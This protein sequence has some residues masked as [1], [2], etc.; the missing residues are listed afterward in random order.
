MSE[1]SRPPRDWKQLRTKII[2]LG[3]ESIRKSYYPELQQRLREIQASEAK[4]RAIFDSVTDA[5]LVQ[6]IATGNI[7]DVNRPMCTPF[8][9]SCDEALQLTIDQLSPNKAPY[10]SEAF[11]DRISKATQGE[12][13]TF[14]WLIQTKANTQVWVEISL[15]RAL[16]GS[17]ERLLIMIR[18]ITERKRTE[19]EKREF[20]RE[21]ILNVT[22][23][24]LSICDE[25]DI[26]PY[27]DRSTLQIKLNNAADIAQVRNEVEHFC[28]QQILSEDRIN[29]FMIGIGE[30][31]ANAVKHSGC[32]TVFAGANDESVWVGV[33]DKGPGIE[34]LIL[35]RAVL[36]HGFSTKRSLGL[37]YSMMLQVADHIL[38][39]TDKTG[40][41]VLL[42]K[43]CREEVR[44][45]LD[46]IPDTW[47]GIVDLRI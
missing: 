26:Q 47:E 11:Q 23:G 21:T 5:I 12:A 32:G 27:Q 10:T 2:G 22:D 34:S 43:N 38:L 31:I 8:G 20:Y 13:Q 18:D 37:G 16:I 45:A 24:K 35:P 42:L 9:Y 33:S 1:H 14:E 6:D 36:R 46:M 25:I 19:E 17:E 15:H 44:T 29:E 41:S 7:L 4:F 39:K 3:D 28:K 40:T 30:A